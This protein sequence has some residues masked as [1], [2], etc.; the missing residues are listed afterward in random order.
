MP[1]QIHGTSLARRSTKYLH[2][3]VARFM[4]L[5][6]SLAKLKEFYPK[7]NNVVER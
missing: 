7:I 2:L 6:A 5:M 4:H 1:R 3:V